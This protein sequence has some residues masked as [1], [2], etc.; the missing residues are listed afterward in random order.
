MWARGLGVETVRAVLAVAFGPLDLHR[1]W[2]AL[3]PANTVSEETLL[4]AGFVDEERIRQHV[5]VDVI[6]EVPVIRAHA[7]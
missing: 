2:A 6:G 4:R 7:A 3:S 5:F 1:V